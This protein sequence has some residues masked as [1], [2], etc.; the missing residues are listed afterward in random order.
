VIAKISDNHW[1]NLAVV[2][3]GVEDTLAPYFSAKHPR[4]HYI[5]TSAAWDGW[6]RRYN[7]IKQRLALPFRQDLEACCQKHGIPLDIVDSRTPE[8]IPSIDDIKPDM[9]SGVTLEEY[10]LDAVKATLNHEVG[11]ISSC[12]GS[13]KCITGESRIIVNGIQINICDLFVDMKDEEIRDVHDFG[14]FTLCANGYTRINKLYKTN[15]RNVYKLSLSNKMSLRGVYE[16]KVY[17]KHGWSNLGDLKHGDEIYTRKSLDNSNQRS[18]NLQRWKEISKG[19]ENSSYSIRLYTMRAEVCENTEKANIAKSEM[20]ESNIPES[21]WAIVE[22]IKQDGMEYCYDIQVD[23]ASHSYWSNG[24]LSH[25]TEIMCALVKFYGY[26]T[27]IITEQLVVLDQIVNRLV[28]RDVAKE[29]GVGVFCSGNMPSGQKIIV[30][31]IQSITSPTKPKLTDIN[32]PKERACI[33][34]LK[35]LEEDSPELPHMLPQQA[36]NILKAEPARVQNLKGSLLEGVCDYFREKEYQ[37]R[38][39]WYVTRYKRAERI[40]GLISDCQMMLVDEADLAVSQ[41]YTSLCRKV[42]NGRRRYGFSGTPFDKFKPVENLFLRENLGNIIYEVPRHKVQERNRIIPVHCYFI[43]VGK[44]GDRKDARTYDIAMREEIVD[45]VKFHNLVVKIV[46]SFKNDR[47]LILIDTSPVGELGYAL[48]KLIPGSKFL[49]NKSAPSERSK[50]IK[51]FEAGEIRY[52]IGGKIFKRGL[53]LKGGVDNLIIIGGGKQHSNINQMVGRAV[54]LNDRG[55]ARIFCFFFLNNKYLYG[56]SRENLK[57][58]VELGYQ[59]RV[60]VNGKQIDAE[61]FIRSRYKV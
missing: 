37:R 51:K 1:L 28:I 56:H 21:C 6:Y 10:Q 2:T 31:S 38:T 32:I 47:T 26:N 49:W 44:D 60:L 55:W 41:Q 14:L 13:G 40:Q 50:F 57:A 15:K 54:R 27:V 17:T 16:H 46:S 39:K 30:G 43:P 4:A 8:Q 35:L 34:L 42:F 9:L 23:D 22:S 29:D 3:Q 53:D 45:N 59:T 11:L 52:L 12:T 18:D 25:N 7:T 58:V 5:D 36:I 61:Q 19:Y 33:N 48:E 24:I 20:W